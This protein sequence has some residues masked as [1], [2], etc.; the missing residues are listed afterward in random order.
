M[1]LNRQQYDQYDH[2]RSRK[3][4]N[5]DPLSAP[6]T[7]TH[8]AHCPGGHEYYVAFNEGTCWIQPSE[9]Y[10]TGYAYAS[11]FQDGCKFH[12]LDTKR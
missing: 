1:F 5:L 12:E 9:F 6:K 8:I 2:Q 11:L 3:A 7:A 4:H 10:G